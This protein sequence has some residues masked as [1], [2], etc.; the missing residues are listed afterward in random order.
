ME[1]KPANKSNVRMRLAL[2]GPSGSGKTYSALQLAF[3]L[4]KTQNIAVIDTEARSAE[5]YSNLGSFN[6]VSVSPPFT[7]ERFIEAID[8]CEDYG[9]DVIIIDS[10]SHAWE[11]PGGILEIHGNMPGNSFANWSRVMPRHNALIQTFMHSSAH[12]I[13]TLRAKQDYIIHDRNGRMAPEKIGLKPVQKEGIDYEFTLALELD[14]HHK[15][16]ASKDRTG[17]FMDKDPFVITP[18]TGKKLADWCQKPEHISNV[19][20][21]IS[22]T[23]IHHQNGHSKY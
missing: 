20:N 9:C 18:S 8:M 5:L 19:I 10:L 12:I 1:L 23:L 4:S 3:G 6:V 21:T 15:A 11:G 22:N 7:P 13:V 17:L 14:I 16:K 2:H